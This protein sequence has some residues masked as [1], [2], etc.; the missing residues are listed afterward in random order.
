[1]FFSFLVKLFSLDS[2]HFRDM[3]GSRNR[4]IIVLIGALYRLPLFSQLDADGHDIFWH[5][6]DAVLSLSGK[7]MPS[8]FVERVQ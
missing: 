8:F 7:I 4:M 5:A 2:L 1:M 3:L 6:V